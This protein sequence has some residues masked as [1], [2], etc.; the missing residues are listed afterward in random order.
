[1][2]R[3]NFIPTPM[4]DES[5]K[6]IYSGRGRFSAEIQQ[7]IVNT[8]MI[9]ELQEKWIP[10]DSNNSDHV[11]MMTEAKAKAEGTRNITKPSMNTES[12]RSYRIANKNEIPVSEWVWVAYNPENA[13]HVQSYTTA[14]NSMDHAKLT[15]DAKEAAAK[16][17]A[18]KRRETL[19]KT[20]DAAKALETKSVMVV[21][22]E[23]EE[24][25]EL[26]AATASDFK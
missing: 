10:F 15:K 13:K 21:A 23:Q 17:R 4:L 20:I 22:S 7:K 5:G 24:K 11:T 14:V 12:G 2:A 25:P 9:P 1:M 16:L 19:Q 6:E 18:A 8:K 3:G 26:E